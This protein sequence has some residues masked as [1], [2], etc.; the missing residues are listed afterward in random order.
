MS[1]HDFTD[2]QILIRDT[3]RDFAR[4]ELL[5]VAAELDR[6][7]GGEVY[8]ANLRKL[9]QLGFNGLCVREDLGGAAAGMVAQ[10]LALYEIGGACISTAV[11]VSINNMVAEVVQ[12]TGSEDLARRFLPPLLEG[13]HAAASFCLTE[14]SAGSDPASLKTTA[15]LDGDDY[16][17]NGV[18]QWITSG[19]IAGF[20]VVW[21]KTDANAKKGAGI[22]CFVVD[23][24]TKGISHNPPADKMGQHAS[25]SN[26]IVFQDVR[27]QKQ[28]MLGAAND[29]F[30][31]AMRELCGGR[32]GVA[33]MVM[34][35]SAAALTAARD[36]ML[37]REQHGKKLAEHQGLQWMLAKR[38][39]ELEAGFWLV[40]RAAKLKDAGRAYAKEASMAKLYATAAAENIT[41]DALQIFGGYGYMRALP[42][43]RY[44]RDVRLASIYEGSS[45]IQQIIIARDLLQNGGDNI[46]GD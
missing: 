32:I 2:T 3:A 30:R 26:D 11:A 28:D 4:S 19:E 29:G 23:A 5:P 33:A 40:V 17:I 21:A 42:M 16:V 36:Y 9:A 24:K 25:P 34:G 10:A 13:K 35:A 46:R 31:I 27:V 7:R 6:T 22:S 41:R 8:A 44:C 15:V 38:A 37:E 45:E 14:S 20:L 1:D 43:E 18:K 39:T 12:N